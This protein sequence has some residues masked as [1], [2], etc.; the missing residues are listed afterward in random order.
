MG[1]TNNLHH[2]IMAASEQNLFSQI[3]PMPN[4]IF[5]ADLK[6]CRRLTTGNLSVMFLYGAFINSKKNLDKTKFPERKMLFGSPKVGVKIRLGRLDHLPS[7]FDRSL[8]RAL[9]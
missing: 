5:S 3:R 1:D 7:D 2:L 8:G 4:N 6:K 9:Q